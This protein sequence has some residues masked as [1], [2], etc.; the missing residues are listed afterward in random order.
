VRTAR[1]MGEDDNDGKE[2]NSKDD[3]E[4]GKDDRQ[5]L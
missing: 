1:T 5:G 3:C 2:D 4:D